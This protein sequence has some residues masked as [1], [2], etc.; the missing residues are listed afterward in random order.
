MKTR[1]V[2]LDRKTGDVCFELEPKFELNA[3]CIY[4]QLVDNF[5]KWNICV[6]ADTIETQLQELIEN[7]LMSLGDLDALKK[8]L[9]GKGYFL[10]EDLEK[11]IKAFVEF[12]PKKTIVAKIKKIR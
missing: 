12:K 4:D 11:T 7:K 10:P 5:G 6:G 3:F 1:L 9:K 8:E 2:F